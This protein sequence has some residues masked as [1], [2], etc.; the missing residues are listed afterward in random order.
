MC[1][2]NKLFSL[3][4]LIPLEMFWQ[5]KFKLYRLFVFCF[6]CRNV[7]DVIIK[8]IFDIKINHRTVPKNRYFFHHI[9]YK[10]TD[11]RLT[12]VEN[13]QK[14]SLITGTVVYCHLYRWQIPGT[15]I[16]QHFLTRN[17]IKGGGL[18]A[19]ITGTGDYFLLN[20]R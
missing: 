2:P 17:R 15:V 8:K 3:F 14:R 7:F 18:R 11:K 6:I 13:I 16:V 20:R 1:L 10:C 12:S 19:L 4:R 9:R 5:K